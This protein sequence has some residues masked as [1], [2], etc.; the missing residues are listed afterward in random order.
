ME[1]PRSVAEGETPQSRLPWAL[2]QELSRAQRY[3]DTAD[4]L[5]I[6]LDLDGRITLINRKGREL[7]GW[8]EE[9][10]LGRNWIETCLPARARD[11]VQKAFDSLVSGDVAIV[12][13]PILTKDGEE[14]QIEW[15][16][17][18]LRGDDGAI[19]GT[20]SSGTDI[21]ERLHAEMELKRLTNEIEVQRLR[22]FKATI[23]TVQVIVNNLL[24]G[25]QLVHLEDGD[26]LAHEVPA[27]VE[28]LIGD[29]TGDLRA[30]GNL[31]TVTEKKMAIGSGIEYA[32]ARTPA[33]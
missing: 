29:A 10:L 2:R 22:V 6:A 26:Q 5:L 23:R 3:F 14:R 1:E 30:L 9:E 15:H 28:R 27:L 8:T 12:D 4:V 13:N 11:V 7:L 24:N 17:T 18:V 20:F 33:D 16:N 31:E 32:V 25:L 21:T 19:I